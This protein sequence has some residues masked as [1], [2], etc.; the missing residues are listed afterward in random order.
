MAQLALRHRMEHLLADVRPEWVRPSSIHL[1]V[2]WKCN[3]N[4]LHCDIPVTGQR[5]RPLLT[6]EQICEYLIQLKE[7]LGPYQFNIAGGE[8]FIRSD[9]LDII[10][11]AT[12]KGIK[13]NLTT[14]GMLLD[15]EK[16]R[17]LE[18]SGIN[19]LNISLDSLTPEIHDRTRNHPG[20]HGRVMAVIE[21]LNRPRDY[22]L[23]LSTIVMGPNLQELVPLADWVES[24]GLNGII[25]QPLFST[26]GRPYRPDWWRGNELFPK[27]LAEVDRVLDALIAGRRDGSA[28]VNGVEQLEAMRFHFHNPAAA[29]LPRCRVDVKNFSINEYG[30]ALLCFWL[31]PVGNILEQRPEEVWRSVLA[32]Q[33]RQEIRD[34]KRN[35]SLLNCHFS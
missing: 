26:F 1:S 9:M 5:E 22:C 14:N 15:E 10:E 19:S 13:V 24:R 3:L 21:R 29:A 25:Y 35:C 18:R 31:P 11:F 17:R 32:H 16:A 33:R 23:V 20:C 8:P 7:W 27:D 12:R 4:C 30:E 2:T 28:T 34:C 6:Q